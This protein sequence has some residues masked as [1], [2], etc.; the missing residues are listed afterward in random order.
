MSLAQSEQHEQTRKV[1]RHVAEAV[2]RIEE[3]QRAAAG[4]EAVFSL[5]LLTL[6][7]RLRELTGKLLATKAMEV[8]WRKAFHEPVALARKLREGQLLTKAEL[9]LVGEAELG[10]WAEGAV[11]WCLVCLGALC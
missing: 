6:R 8:Y 7:A 9:A 3:R 4:V 1:L 5:E 2:R 10:V 11:V